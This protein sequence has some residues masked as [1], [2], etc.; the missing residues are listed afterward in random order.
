MHFQVAGKGA[1][2]VVDVVPEK[3]GG[4]D[5]FGVVAL[6]LDMGKRNAFGAKLV[7]VREVHSR[8][9]MIEEQ[10]VGELV[11][12]NPRDPRLNWIGMGDGLLECMHVVRLRTVGNEDQLGQ[13]P[14]NAK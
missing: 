8:L 5:V 10:V 6:G 1:A 13:H 11:E 2:N 14:E 4:K 7:E 9:A 3:Q 12:N